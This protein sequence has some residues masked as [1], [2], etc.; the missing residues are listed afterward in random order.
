MYDA[1]KNAFCVILSLNMQ[2]VNSRLIAIIHVFCLLSTVIV[3]AFIF[4]LNAQ[5]KLPAANSVRMTIVK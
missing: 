3:S 1:I 2:N 5:R 4:L